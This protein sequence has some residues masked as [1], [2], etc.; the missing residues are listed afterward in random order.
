MKGRLF[1]ALALLFGFRSL[2]QNN[3]VRL[4]TNGKVANV[5]E[6]GAKADGVADDTTAINAALTAASSGGAVFVPPGTYKVAGTLVVPAN[7]SFYGAGKGSELI[8]QIPEKPGAELVRL[9]GDYAAIS[10]LW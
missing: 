4:S 3:G 10:D 6:F 1:I 7:V 2:G 9:S 5:M 8:S